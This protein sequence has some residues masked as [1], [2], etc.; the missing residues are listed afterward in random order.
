MSKKR[1]IDYFFKPVHDPQVHYVADNIGEVEDEPIYVEPEEIREVEEEPINT[2]QE[3][4]SLHEVGK[5]STYPLL[6]R[7]IRLILTL[8]VSTA[9][10]ERAFSTMKI[11][12][13][14]L[15]NTMTDDFLRSYLLVNI[16]REIADTFSTRIL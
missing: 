2:E 15:R 5:S 6:D 11:V 16:E 1:T 10:S 7:L 3:E 13:T 12:K 9:T 14:R 8:P 4:I